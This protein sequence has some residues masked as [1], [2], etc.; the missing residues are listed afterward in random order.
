MNKVFIL[1]MLLAIVAAQEESDSPSDMPS[2]IGS[3][4][5]AMMPTPGSPE[6]PTPSG[7]SSSAF[8]ARA[9]IGAA[10]VAVGSMFL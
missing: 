9:F 5:P 2:D 4:T 7:G 8:V 3:P 10:V 6:V 1:S